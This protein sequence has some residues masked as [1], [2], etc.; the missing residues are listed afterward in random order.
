[1]VII[2][3]LNLCIKATLPFR[4]PKNEI[5]S[6]TSFQT[7]QKGVHTVWTFFGVGGCWVDMSVY[8][9]HLIMAE[10]EASHDLAQK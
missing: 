10:A 8:L 9:R 1:M 4:P 5:G 3:Q 7:Y 2:F 6:R